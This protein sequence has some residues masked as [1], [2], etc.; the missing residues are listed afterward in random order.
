MSCSVQFAQEQVHVSDEVELL[1]LLQAH[2]PAP[3][4][5]TRLVV[6]L[7]DSQP[8]TREL[9]ALPTTDDVSV[10]ICDLRVC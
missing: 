10:F 3:L 1:V 7:R 2:V 6:H 4:H 5:C 9:N 8:F